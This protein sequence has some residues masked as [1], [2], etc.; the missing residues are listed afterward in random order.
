MLP[1]GD[2]FGSVLSCGADEVVKRATPKPS[3]LMAY[4]SVF[5]SRADANAI[6]VPAGDQRGTPPS[7]SL[8][9]KSF[10]PEPSRLMT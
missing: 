9:V 1:S 8:V 5:P 10:S 3:G 2:Q 4:S 6:G 7:G